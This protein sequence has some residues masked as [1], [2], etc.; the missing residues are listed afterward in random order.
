MKI[1]FFGNPEFCLEP[2]TKLHNSKHSILSVV[3]NKDKKSGRGLN[4]KQTFVKKKA[5]DLKLPIIE[6][7]D[8]NSKELH[9][10]LVLLNA[11][12]FVV[13]AFRILPDS[14][15]NIPKYG[16]INIHPSIL[17]KYR[18]SSPIQYSL[19]NGDSEGGV[20][21]IKLNKNI[22]A[23]H[24]LA[25][26]RLSINCNDTFGDMHNKLS[27]L[28]ANLLISVINDI[29][30]GVQKLLS[31]DHSLKTLAPKIKKEDLKIDWNNSSEEI[32]NRIRAF[33]PFPGAYSFLNQ[34]RIKLFNS[35]KYKIYEKVDGSPGQLIVK[36]NLL[37]IK[38]NN[39]DFINVGMVQIEGKKKI[40]SLDFIKTLSNEK[41]I[42][43]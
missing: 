38:T 43:K 15:I 14:I 4:L 26:K 13:V 41:H 28:G 17:P 42:L 12:L 18:G 23:G 11:D 36:D 22:D 21:I 31:Q 30:S 7:D 5:L 20:S 3:T 2:L 27:V 16:S 9:S 37:L 8:I 24:I 6:V 1:I 32:H 25:Q 10:K 40:S 29:E 35:S 33:D 19:L 39:K 34:K